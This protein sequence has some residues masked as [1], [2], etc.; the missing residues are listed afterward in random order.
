MRRDTTVFTSAKLEWDRR[1]IGLRKQEAEW[2]CGRVG[3]VD[4]SSHITQA[5]GQRELLEELTGATDLSKL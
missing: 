1:E 3:F 5:A 2:V 4:K